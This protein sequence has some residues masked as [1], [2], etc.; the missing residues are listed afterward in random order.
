LPRSNGRNTKSCEATIPKGKRSF[1]D[2][3][4]S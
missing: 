1:D 4:G 2:S 3:I